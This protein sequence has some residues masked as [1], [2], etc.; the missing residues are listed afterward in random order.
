[1]AQFFETR[2]VALMPLL[3]VDYHDRRCVIDNRTVLPSHERVRELGRL[4]AQ[5]HLPEKS[6][7]RLSHAPPVFLSPRSGGIGWPQPPL[8]RVAACHLIPLLSPRCAGLFRF[9]LF[10]FAILRV[11][12]LPCPASLLWSLG[13][14]SNTAVSGSHG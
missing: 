9:D 7:S 2:Y 5:P 6:L 3:T 12:I 1:M 8:R 11:V 10:Q 13:R 14:V 4:I